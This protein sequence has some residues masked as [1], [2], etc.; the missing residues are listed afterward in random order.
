[1]DSLQ[2]EL[3]AVPWLGANHSKLGAPTCL[4]KIA[5]CLPQENGVVQAT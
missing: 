3:N 5:R 1:M 4:L 2:N